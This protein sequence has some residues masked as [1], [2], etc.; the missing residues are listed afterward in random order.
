M[1]I[2]HR[3]QRRY[4]Y[5]GSGIFDVIGS[6]VSRVATK[7]PEVLAR[8][9]ANKLI[10]QVVKKSMTAGQKALIDNSDRLTTGLVN[11]V[12]DKIVKPSA[13]DIVKPSAKDIVAKKQASA[14]INSLTQPQV[15][16]VNLNALISGMGL[17]PVRSGYGIALD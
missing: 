6:L 7:A 13:K 9:Q 12:V 16:P 17:K 11:K 4:A 10:S 1:I 14:L 8:A 3:T 15:T 5:G 2:K